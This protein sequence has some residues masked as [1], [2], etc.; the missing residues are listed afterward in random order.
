VDRLFAEAAQ[1]L[2]ATLGI[3]QNAISAPAREG[4]AV[5]AGIRAAL[6]ALRR[7]MANR[8]SRSRSS[9]DEDALFI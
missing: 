3:I 2:D 8:A 4:A 9:D 1:R 7:S 6:D 5:M